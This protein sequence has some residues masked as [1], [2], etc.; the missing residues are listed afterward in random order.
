MAFLWGETTGFFVPEICIWL[1]VKNTNGKSSHEHLFLFKRVC[2]KN[3]LRMAKVAWNKKSNY[4]FSGTKWDFH[5]PKAL[6]KS[7][8]YKRL[9]GH[10]FFWLVAL[11]GCGFKT[12][13]ANH[14]VRFVYENLQI[15]HVEHVDKYNFTNCT[16][17]GGY[18][19]RSQIH[20]I[21]IT[22]YIYIYTYT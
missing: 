14:P 13:V 8:Y 16:M 3:G 10:R 17:H 15:A 19:L 7:E 6:A 5:N 11:H 4:G 18:G 1:V 2:H 20:V 12:N 9:F 21:V 22:S